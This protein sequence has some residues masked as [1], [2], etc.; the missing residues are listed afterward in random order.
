MHTNTHAAN[1]QTP[2]RTRTHTRKHVHASTHTRTETRL[3]LAGHTA[4]HTSTK[5]HE[6]TYRRGITMRGMK[7][8]NHKNMRHLWFSIGEKKYKKHVT[9]LCFMRK[10]GERGGGKRGGG[11]RK[12]HTQKCS[13]FHSGWA[14]VGS[15]QSSPLPPPPTHT[16]TIYHTTSST[17]ESNMDVKGRKVSKNSGKKI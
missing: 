13:K 16:H 12:E 10:N 3:S 5:A 9:N 8:P 4:Q 14:F 6:H 17:N 2:T 1:T 15:I 7:K 11:S